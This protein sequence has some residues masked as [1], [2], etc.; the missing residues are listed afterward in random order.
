MTSK[1][2]PPA[3]RSQSN[4]LTPPGDA[5]RYTSVVHGRNAKPMNGTRNVSNAASHRAGQK[6]Q[7]RMIAARGPR[8]M[9]VTSKHMS[10]LRHQL[11]AGLV[12]GL[13]LLGT[14]RRIGQ[15]ESLDHADQDAGHER[16]HD[17]LVV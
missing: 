9:R 7:Y 13:E 4:P 11:G 14:D 5:S 3:T 6:P 1:K 12:D 15:I 17:V 16:P 8:S 2:N 10:G